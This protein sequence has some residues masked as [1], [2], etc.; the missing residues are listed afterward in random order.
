MRK[1]EPP[2]FVIKGLDEWLYSVKNKAGFELLKEIVLEEGLEGI[3]ASEGRLTI[4]ESIFK[5]GSKYY[6]SIL[7]HE[8][9]HLLDVEILKNH[10]KILISTMNPDEIKDILTNH[11]AVLLHQ[12]YE[13][14]LDSTAE[15]LKNDY[16]FKNL[17]IDIERRTKDLELSEAIKTFLK[18]EVNKHSLGS[19]GHVLSYKNDRSKIDDYLK[20]NYGI[21]SL[22]SFVSK[23]YNL[24]YIDEKLPELNGNHRLMIY[25]E[26]SSA[27]AELSLDEKAEIYHFGTDVAQANIET[28]L[29]ISYDAGKIEES[30]F[31]EITNKVPT[32]G[33]IYRGPNLLSQ[34]LCQDLHS[35]KVASYL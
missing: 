1:N 21:P 18:R 28:L 33:K 8:F 30:E 23:P 29:Q 17:L 11:H 16:K 5:K 31:T 2:I 6:L 9:E 22:Y 20:K 32:K 34:S 19:L 14:I 25:P 13:K 27:F 26:L 3:H 4:G 12:H 15:L 10:L 7:D 24:R 35:T